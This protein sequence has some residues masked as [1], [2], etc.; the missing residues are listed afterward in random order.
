MCRPRVQV[1]KTVAVSGGL[2]MTTLLGNY[3]FSAPLDT[4][5][6]LGAAVTARLPLPLPNLRTTP[7]PAVT[8]GV[9]G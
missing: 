7:S 9:L 4:T 2:V 1:S 6:A 5:I 8:R 3:F